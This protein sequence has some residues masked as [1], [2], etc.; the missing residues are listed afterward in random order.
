VTHLDRESVLTHTRTTPSHIRSVA[1][2]DG[3]WRRYGR[4]SDANG[5]T[6]GN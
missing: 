3:N 6:A 1:H 5:C 4:G 2:S